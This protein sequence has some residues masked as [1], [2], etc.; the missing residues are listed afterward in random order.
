MSNLVRML[1]VG[2]SLSFD[3]GRI[4]LSLED[5]SGRTARLRLAIQKD[6]VIDKPR[7]AANDEPPRA[8]DAPIPTP[9]AA[10]G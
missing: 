10:A 2:D 4:V 9:R 5:K 3:G 8:A 6:V 7:V 1:R